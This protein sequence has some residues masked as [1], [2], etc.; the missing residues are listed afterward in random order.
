ML[1]IVHELFSRIVVEIYFN[2]PM[3]TLLSDGIAYF[4]LLGVGLLIP[5]VATFWKRINGRELERHQ[6]GSQLQV[7][8]S[9]PI[10]S[11]IVSAS[12][13]VATLLQ[14]SKVAY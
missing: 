1:M 2:T 12:T 4:V 8:I 13:W 3:S 7:E 5:L 11:P 6:N 9:I 10:T 14:S